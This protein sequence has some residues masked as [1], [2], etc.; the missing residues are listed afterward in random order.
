MSEQVLSQA[1]PSESATPGRPPPKR[2]PMSFD[3][4]WHNLGFRSF[5][6]QVLVIGL[7]VLTATYMLSNAQSA[8]DKRGIKTGFSFLNEEAGFAIGESLIDYDSDQNFIRAYQVAILNTLKVSIVSVLGAT[9]LGVLIGIA[10]LSSNWF[11]SRFSSFYIEI[12]RNTPQLVQIVFWYTL[13]TRMPHPK[14]SWDISEV[15]FFSNRGMVTA[16]PVSNTAYLWIALAWVVAC[17]GAY[18]INRWADQYRRRTGRAIKVLWWNLALIIGL[19]I[20]AW[21]A[22]GTPT[23]MDI[24]KLQGFN[25]VG[26]LALSPEFIALMLGLSLYIAAFIAEIVRA[27]VQAVS[28]GQIEAARAVGLGRID[29]YTKVIL[30]QALRVIIPPATSQYVSLAKNSSLGVAIGYPELF[31]VNN[32][33]TTVSGNT[34]ECIGIMMSVYLCIA[35]SIAIVMNLYNRAVQIKER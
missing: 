33:I 24:P 3:G 9:L 16:W 14:Q 25:F 5:I 17:V 34:I 19:P 7:V 28:R 11:V 6:Y 18:C 8:L 15:I 22:S 12:F 4:L 13:V 20:V 2:A 30:P 26:G 10:R 21:F 1:L 35:F 23:A 27:G 31:N 32:T 29:L